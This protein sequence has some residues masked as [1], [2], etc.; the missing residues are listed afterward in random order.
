VELGHPVVFTLVGVAVTSTVVTT[1]AMMLVLTGLAIGFR[2]T[3]RRRPS[4]WQAVAEWGLRV[5]DETIG[6]MTGGSGERFLP[7][8]ATLGIFVLVANLLSVL[9][10]V[11]APTADIATPAALATIVFFSVHYFGISELGLRTYLMKFAEPMP[12]LL[13]IN[14]LH[15]VSRTLSM[16]VRL[17]GNMISHQIIVAI[18]V[19]MLPLIVPVVLQVFGL[20]IGLL[21]AY[22]FVIL[23]IVYIGGAVRA[24]EGI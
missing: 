6:E 21:Q 11:E 24:G 13:P 22:I 17:F 2:Q 18:L 14:L 1:W 23:T 10:F 20:F 12:I 9:P 7:L 5:L 19:M 15:Y 8:V 4:R 3:I 16:A